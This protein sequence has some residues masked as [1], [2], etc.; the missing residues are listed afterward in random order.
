MDS[1]N[2]IDSILIVGGG[3]AGWI[4]ANLLNAILGKRAD[5]KIAITVLESPNIPKIGVGEATVP[6]I[7]RTLQLIGLSEKDFMRATDAT[8]KNLIRFDG[9]NSGVSYDHPF[10]RRARPDT[11]DAI[12]AWL[13]SADAGDNAFAKKFSLLSHIA[14]AGL[15]PKATGWPDY[16]SP[17]PYAYHLDAIKLALTL[18]EHGRQ[19]GIAHTLTNVTDV[20]LD[21][22]GHISAVTT[23]TDETFSADLY[24]DCTGFRSVLHKQKL[25]VKRQDFSKYLLC[26]RAATLRVP[27]DVYQPGALKPYT[28]SSA[29]S[30]GWSWDIALQGR[31]GLGYVYASAFQSAE[32]AEAELRALE[33]PHCDDLPVQH[34]VFKSGKSQQ[35]WAKNCVAIGL[36]DGFLEPLESSGLYLIEFAAQALGEMLTFIGDDSAPFVKSFNRQM[37]GIYAE[38]LEF[39]NLHYCL[40]TR[41]DTPFW[42]AVQQREHILDSLAE[43]LALWKFKPPGDMDFERPLRLFSLQSYEYILFGMGGRAK[44]I[45]RAASAGKMPDLSDAITKSLARLPSHESW[46]ASL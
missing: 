1:F 9:W 36:S 13:R 41:T 38:V 12:L 17:F 8:F 39:L 23:D 10:D 20:H 18:A 42:Q 35:S 25:G 4:T 27:Y 45:P 31:R 30:A 43:K 28:T 6:S 24:I 7:R 37:D 2:L 44:V 29:R 3:S 32:D 22:R 14:A 5:R 34:I 21:E 33:G 40:S 26:D 19:N 15:A 16:G 46:L 11:D